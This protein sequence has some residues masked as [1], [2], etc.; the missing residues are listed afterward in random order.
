MSDEPAASSARSLSLTWTERHVPNAHRAVRRLRAFNAAVLVRDIRSRMRGGR[1][2]WMMFGFVMCFGLCAVI[3]LPALMEG[4]RWSG[5]PTLAT[6]ER[7]GR[8][9]F[10]ILAVTQFVLVTLLGPALTCGAITMERQ[11]QTLELL[12]VSRLSGL[13]VMLG[14]LWAAGSFLLMLLLCTLPVASLAFMF[15]G[16]SIQQVL[17]A[18]LFTA[19]AGGFFAALGLFWSTYAKN[20]SAATGLAVGSD[21]AILGGPLLVVGIAAV[22]GSSMSEP[23]LTDCALRGGAVAWLTT[24]VLGY[25]VGRQLWGRR[26][27]VLGALLGYLVP[28]LGLSLAAGILDA[29]YDRPAPDYLF[30]HPVATA[31]YIAQPSE[32]PS[33]AGFLSWTH[34]II[35]NL[36]LF[37]LGALLLFLLCVRGFR[38]RPGE[39]D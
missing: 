15:G 24:G 32:M 2:F 7:I 33:R 25:F 6:M 13:D 34:A 18:Y 27:A 26:R 10:M 36:G 9:F 22:S 17:T 8:D 14:K 4:L 11:Q 30:L 31:F 37:C 23:T 1:G 29:A 5:A 20:T 28:W 16:V 3:A 39:T 35:I 12:Q 38:T 19:V 21:F